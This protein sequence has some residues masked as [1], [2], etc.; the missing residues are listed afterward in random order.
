MP[1]ITFEQPAF[2]AAEARALSR[3]EYGIDANIGRPQV[4]YRET[5]AGAAEAAHVEKLVLDLRLNGG[6]NNYLNRGFRP[7]RTETY[8]AN[9]TG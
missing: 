8:P 2:T 5:L 6:G 9:V 1:T 3:R 4:V 7:Y